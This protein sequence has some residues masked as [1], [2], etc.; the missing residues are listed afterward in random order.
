ELEVEVKGAVKNINQAEWDSLLSPDESPFMEYDWIYCMEE[1]GCATEETG[2][3]PLHFLTTT[4]VAPPGRLL[5]AVPMYLKGHS[6]GEFIFDQ[7]FAEASLHWG[8]RYYP[9]LLVGVPFTPAAGS[10]VLIDPTL[11]DA[12]KHRIRVAVAVF[13]AN[14]AANSG[15]SS[16]H[17]NFCSDAEVRAFTEAGFAHRKSLQVRCAAFV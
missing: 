7:Q 17:V 2:W 3:R 6:M 16:V 4:A 9:K 15:V 1:S 11:D 12:Y 14:T 5:A 8:V 13:L 10:R